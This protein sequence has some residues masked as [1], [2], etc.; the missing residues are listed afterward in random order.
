MR[1]LHIDLGRT[2]R[3]GQYQA[4]SLIRELGPDSV[5]LARPGTPLFAE[6][7]RIGINIKAFSPAALFKTRCDL[8]HAHDA[9]SHQWLALLSRTPFVVSRRVAFPV[10]RS[11]ISRWKYA[12]A[13]HYL[14]ISQ[15]VK[16][17]LETAGVPATKI[18]VVYDGVYVPQHPSQGNSIV[19]LASGDPMKGAALVKQAAAIGGLDIVFSTDLARD[20]QTAALFV[21]IT[22]SEGLGSAAL[23]AMASGVPVVASNVGGLPEIVQDGKTGVLT[24][25]DPA[26]IANAIQKALQHRDQL[27]VTAR[28]TIVRQF[29][30]DTMV[31]N[32]MQVYQKVLSCY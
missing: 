23:M 8:A 29:T 5:L 32:T 3:G 4:L 16:R 1:I 10:E 9:L 2:L 17:V 19:T 27:A 7:H 11:R 20:L 15:H 30:V 26:S 14:A 13:D 28:E 21:Y 6:A 12:R 22:H 24:Q 25:N 31:S 18:S